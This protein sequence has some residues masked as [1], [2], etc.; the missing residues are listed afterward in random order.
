MP[1]MVSRGSL[2]LRWFLAQAETLCSMGWEMRVPDL[3]S[4]CHL[5]DTG[6]KKPLEFGV[7]TI[8]FYMLD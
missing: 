7:S 1:T 3:W 2:I 4:G 8:D 5:C 6:Q